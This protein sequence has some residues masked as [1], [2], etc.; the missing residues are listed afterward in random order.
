M[1]HKAQSQVKELSQKQGIFPVELL[2]QLNK[3]RQACSPLKLTSHFLLQSINQFK[4]MQPIK[5]F[6]RIQSREY[7]YHHS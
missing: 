3:T 2:K 7:C 6:D 4:L 1:Q 5:I